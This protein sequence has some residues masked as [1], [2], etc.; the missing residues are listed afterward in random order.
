MMVNVEILNNENSLDRFIS[1]EKKCSTYIKRSQL[2][3]LLDGWVDGWVD[4]WMDGRESRVK[5]CL[6]QSKIN[7]EHL[8]EQ[9]GDLP[10]VQLTRH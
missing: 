3:T 1:D 2:K 6:Q 10:L 7:A 5:D 4:G 8:Y 9:E